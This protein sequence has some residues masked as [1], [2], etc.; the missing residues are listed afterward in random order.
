M[1]YCLFETTIITDYYVCSFFFFS[2]AFN[3]KIL[4]SLWP[5]KNAKY[6]FG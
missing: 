6:C 4:H 2:I 3:C 5:M 1:T